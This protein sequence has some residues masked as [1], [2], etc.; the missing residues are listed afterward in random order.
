VEWNITHLKENMLTLDGLRPILPIPKSIE[1]IL[2]ISVKVTLE[3]H[4]VLEG[5]SNIYVVQKQNHKITTEF[6]KNINIGSHTLQNSLGFVNTN[7]PL[8]NISEIEIYAK[9]NTWLK[10]KILISGNNYYINLNEGDQI[11]TTNNNM[12]LRIS[13]SKN[14]FSY[15][16]T[17]FNK[18]ISN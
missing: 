10:K 9:N 14:T 5:Y 1:G 11:T 4:D 2:N 6:K 12:I 15:I 3:N 13:K 7:N 18:I 8:E 16:S 17:P